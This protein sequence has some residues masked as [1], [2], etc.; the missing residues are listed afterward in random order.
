MLAKMFFNVLQESNFVA[1]YVF[2]ARKRKYKRTITKLRYIVL[3]FY[4]EYNAMPLYCVSHALLILVLNFCLRPY[5]ASFYCSI[6]TQIFFNLKLFN[7]N[8]V[9]W[10]GYT[11]FGMSTV[12]VGTPVTTHVVLWT[13]SLES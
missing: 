13:S 1:R 4:L 9:C 10:G 8:L 7:L 6:C 11:G 12:P 2:K 3:F 5:P